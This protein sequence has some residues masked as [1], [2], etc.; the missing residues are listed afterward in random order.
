[1]KSQKL[2]Q[3]N[4]SKE[5]M[6]TSISMLIMMTYNMDGMFTYLS[7]QLF[8]LAPHFLLTCVN[9]RCDLVFYNMNSQFYSYGYVTKLLLMCIMLVNIFELFLYCRCQRIK[10]EFT[11]EYNYLEDELNI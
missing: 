2:L 9:V 4:M 6:C 5:L 11:F 8:C 3:M 7:H 1:M 10:T